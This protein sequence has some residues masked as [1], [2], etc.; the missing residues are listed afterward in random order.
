MEVRKIHLQSRERRRNW[1]TKQSFYLGNFDFTLTT[2]NPD[3][4]Q[5]L[6]ELPVEYNS[7]IHGTPAVSVFFES[8]SDAHRNRELAAG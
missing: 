8:R 3:S 4:I 5:K 6:S 2:T 1:L 7:N